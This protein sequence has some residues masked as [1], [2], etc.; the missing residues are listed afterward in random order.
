MSSV[1]PYSGDEPTCIKCG[2]A[3]AR[4]EYLAYGE[5]VPGLTGNVTISFA[6]NERLQREC[7]RCGFQWDEAIVEPVHQGG[8]A[9]DCQACKGTNPD[10]PFICPG[11]E[12]P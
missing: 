12:T 5:T 4:T 10:Y 6:P 11:P 2:N 1:P 9:E 8:N 3:G 7:Q